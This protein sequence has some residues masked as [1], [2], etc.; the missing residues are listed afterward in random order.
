MNTE[1]LSAI[2]TA[3]VMAAGGGGVI[4]WR[5]DRREGPITRRQADVAVAQ[6]GSQ[7]K[8]ADIDGLRDILEEERTRRKELRDEVAELS[9][10]VQEAE[11]S[12][13]S[14]EER[15]TT[16]ERR[17][18]EAEQYIEDLIAH[19]P[20]GKPPPQRRRLHRRG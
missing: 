8:V 11:D 18:D 6:V 19:W 16:A 13:R 9:R 12:A 10:R 5:K 2:I 15:A 17:A 4:A 1:L 3:V 7:I 14:A 20:P